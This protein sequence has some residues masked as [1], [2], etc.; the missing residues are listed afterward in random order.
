MRVGLPLGCAVFLFV[1]PHAAPGQVTERQPGESEITLPPAAIPPDQVLAAVT[2]ARRAVHEHRDSAEAY[3]QLG[4]A[5]KSAGDSVGALDAINL[6]LSLNPRL[7]AAWLEKGRI[8]LESDK[9]IPAT[10]DFRKAVECDPRSVAARLELAYMFFRNGDFKGARE[11]LDAVLGLEPENANAMDGLGYIEM[12]QGALQSAVTRFRQASP[13]V[14]IFR[15]RSKTSGTRYSCS[16]IGRGPAG[17]SRRRS[18]KG[19]RRPCPPTD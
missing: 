12:Q 10:E 16:E 4:T 14:Q 6:S 1:S 3:L 7:S 15:R 8:A 11:Q 19:P 13:N 9:L 5:L 2:V 18:R 17:P